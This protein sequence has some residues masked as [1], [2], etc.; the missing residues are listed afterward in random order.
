M[1]KNWYLFL[2]VGLLLMGCDT[3]S[4]SFTSLFKSFNRQG[5]LA[6]IGNNMVIP[7]FNAT[8]AD[9]Q[10]LNASLIQLKQNPN[11]TTLAAAQQSWTNLNASW[12]TA[13]VYGFGAMDYLLVKPKIDNYHC[14]EISIEN[15]ISTAT[16]IDANYVSALPLTDKGL[17]AMEYLLFGNGTQNVEA[18]L[19]ADTQRVNYLEAL[20]VNVESQIILVKNEWAAAGDNYIAGF[21]AADGNSTSSSLG[22]MINYEVM[23]MDEVK[24]MKLGKPMGK[25]DATVLP[26]EV[27]SYYSK[28]SLDNITTNMQALENLF[29]GNGSVGIY[30]L[31]N[32]LGA[33]DN[34]GVLL[35][36]KLDTKFTEIETDML[37]INSN[38]DVAVVNEWNDCDVLYNDVYD[39]YILIKVD[40][41]NQLGLLLTFNDNDGD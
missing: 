3:N 22:K 13:E 21:I 39:L 34:N 15:N 30:D 35:S 32:H 40:V 41:M 14:S 29:T 5:M 28:K 20:G 24:N 7:A 10:D 33:K 6:N 27:E 4:E 18:L 19:S 2:V 26:L 9:A 25:Q 12:R 37:S 17:V 36:T 38:L 23:I 11:A 8:V 16:T 31:L 1:R